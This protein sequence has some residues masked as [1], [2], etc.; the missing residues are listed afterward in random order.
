VV[1]LRLSAEDDSGEVC[2]PL[3]IRAR[4]LTRV[5]LNYTRRIRSA[6]A[7][8]KRQVGCARPARPHFTWLYTV[9]AVPGLTC[10]A[11][12]SSR[13]GTEGCSAGSARRSAGETPDPVTPG[14]VRREGRSHDASLHQLDPVATATAQSPPSRTAQ[15]GP[16]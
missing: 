5:N 10:S 8:Q 12:G 16:V 14:T 9:S 11:P 3:P 1:L 7:R 2:A 4:A 13:A 15:T 6:R